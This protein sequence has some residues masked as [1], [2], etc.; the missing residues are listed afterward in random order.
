MAV[1]RWFDLIPIVAIIILISISNVILGL[2]WGGVFMSAGIGLSLSVSYSSKIITTGIV[3]T[4]SLFFISSAVEFACF[5]NNWASLGDSW[6]GV[7]INDTIVWGLLYL[8][9]I[10]FVAF[11]CFCISAFIVAFLNDA[12]KKC[13]LHYPKINQE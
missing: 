11:I 5:A 1:A 8:L 6:D 9:L 3:S 7:Y 2:M 13:S 12:K 4:G 10:S